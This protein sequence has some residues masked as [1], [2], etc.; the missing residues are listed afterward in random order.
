MCCCGNDC[1]EAAFKNNI[2]FMFY[3]FQTDQIVLGDGCALCF[4]PA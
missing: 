4:T 3:F 1:R 2:L